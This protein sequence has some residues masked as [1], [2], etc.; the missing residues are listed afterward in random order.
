MRIRLKALQRLLQ[1]LACLILLSHPAEGKDYKRVVAIGNAVVE[2]LY[3]LG[4]DDRIAAVDTTAIFPSRA[5]KEKPNVGYMRALSP[6]GVLALDPDLILAEEGAGPATAIAVLKQS[7]VPFVSIPTTTSAEGVPGTIRLIGKTMGAEE[8]AEAL[9]SAVAEDLA[10]VAK[11]VER[12]GEP[13]KVIFVLSFTGGKLLAAGHGTSAEG[14]IAMAGGRN[15]LEG[16]QGY[17]Q[18]SDEAVA[19]A[20]PEAV[21]AMHRD[22]HPVS[23]EIAFSTAALRDTP[24]AREGKF[25]A[26]NGAFLLGFGPRTAHAAQALAKALHPEAKLTPLPERPWTKDE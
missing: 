1:G 15:A 19:V 7:S 13:V 10:T 25:I 14:I 20:A 9:A 12:L 3:A 22:N 8:K 6:E 11:D 21:L 5:L 4:L 18:A 23:A 2:T 26:M 16:F 17:K 24:A